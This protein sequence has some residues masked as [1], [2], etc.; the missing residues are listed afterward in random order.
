MY[1]KEIRQNEGKTGLY[2][3]MKIFTFV[4]SHH[5]K[6]NSISVEKESC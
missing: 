4:I 5:T 2:I 3:H 6:I 1:N